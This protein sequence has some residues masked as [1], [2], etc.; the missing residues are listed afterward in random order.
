MSMQEMRSIRLS[1]DEVSR[2]LSAEIERILGVKIECKINVADEEFWDVEFVNQ[3]LPLPE[4][5]HFIHSLA[6]ILDDW[7]D[8]LP[9]EVRPDI[10]S[11]GPYTGE[12]IIGHHLHIT[13]E[14]RLIAEDGL[15]L[16]GI[17]ESEKKSA[18]GKNDGMLSDNLTQALSVI[19]DH[20]HQQE[21]RQ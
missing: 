2:I 8:A 16:I 18:M 4:Y 19:T 3:H 20:L 6:P 11:M 1:W 5:C 12:K 21:V 10:G 15:W 9:D 17:A 7:A 13:W 14:H